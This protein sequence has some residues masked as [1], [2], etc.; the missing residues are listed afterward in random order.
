[1]KNLPSI[2]IITITYN[3]N[4]RIFKQSLDSVKSQA[5]PGGIIEQIVVDGGSTN[6][7]VE[8]AKSYGSLVIKRPDL[9]YESEMRKS[10][11]IKRSKN[12]IVLFLESDNILVG[13][14][15]LH[16]M[17]LP[18]IDD[19]DIFCTFSMHNSYLKNM[20][21]LT[22]YCALIGASDPPVCY[23]GKADKM[24]LDQ[25][26]YDKGEILKDLPK[27]TKV[28]F[29]KEN[30]PTFGDNGHMVRRS[31]ITMVNKDPRIFLHTDA[32]FDLLCLGYDTYG[33]VKNSVIHDIG[34]NVLQLYQR[35][36]VYKERFRDAYIRKRVYLIFDY[37]SP[38][39]RWN[40]FMYIV[41]SFTLVQPFFRALRGY[42][43]INEPAWFLH[44]FVCFLAAVMYIKSEIKYLANTLLKR[45]NYDKA[46]I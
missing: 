27:Y 7:T 30:L 2:S 8:L 15:W 23:L 20:S 32:F 11:G 43:I 44:P 31:V 29:T 19:V 40:L 24:M 17:V 10:I 14:D 38:K 9:K 12:D 21:L 26:K 4:L 22:K 42:L 3:A 25:K 36:V 18:F 45:I 34:S 16:T 13:K 39:D 41:Y 28:K 46:N 35:R 5:Y 1:M 37:N 6:G 33:V